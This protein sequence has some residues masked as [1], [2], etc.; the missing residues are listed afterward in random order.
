VP[1][2]KL[3]LGVPLYYREWFGQSVD[4]G[5]MREAQD[6]ARKWN[7]KIAFDPEQH[8]AYCTFSDGHEQ[9]SM[10]LQDDQSIR[11][12]IDLADQ[13]HLAGISSWRLGFEADTT[14]DNA[15]PKTIKQ[16]R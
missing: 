10:W 1:A 2:K 6:L 8:E 4:T 5:S 11:E 16:I 13:Y 3:L 15:L 7:A 14:W 9:H 12:K